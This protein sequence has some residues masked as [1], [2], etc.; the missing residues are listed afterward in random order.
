METTEDEAPLLTFA[1]GLA[2][3]LFFLSLIALER[4]G[5]TSGWRWS[6]N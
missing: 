4:E 2:A 6:R 3:P 1:Q 5:F